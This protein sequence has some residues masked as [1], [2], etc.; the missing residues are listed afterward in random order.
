MDANVLDTINLQQLGDELQRARK[1]QG[2]T[3]AEA[4]RIIDVARTTIVAIEKGERRLKATEL[5]KLAQAYGRPVSDFVAERPKIESFEVQF[6]SAY[7]RVEAEDNIQYYIIEFEE[8]CRDYLQIEYLLKAPLNRKYP[9]EYAVQGHP[10]E[11]TAESIALEERNRL[12]MGDGPIPM[13]RDILEHDVGLRVFYMDLPLQFTEMYIYTDSL[14]GCM[15]INRNHPDEQRRWFMAQAYAHFLT[16]RYKPFLSAVQRNPRIPESE[17]FADAFRLFFL[18]PASGL[19]R[20][21]HDLRRIKSQVTLGDLYALSHYYGVSL[22]ALIR[23]LEDMKL[24]KA[25]ISSTLRQDGSRMDEAQKQLGLP[26]IGGRASLLPTRYQYLAL[27][28]FYQEL[29]GEGQFARL[30]RVDRLEARR[31]ARVMKAKAGFLD[32]TA[33]SQQDIAAPAGA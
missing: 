7:R 2:M 24:I 30:L 32:A 29:I 18:M 33:Q 28:A 14:G 20:R 6:L 9:A 23:R 22:E 26:D 13:L 16:S 11:R 21:F 31:I 17:R 3:Q 27:D 4:A 12:D 5:L 8:L 19:T 10:I 1:R 25:G 15:A